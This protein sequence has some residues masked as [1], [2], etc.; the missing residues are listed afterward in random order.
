MPHLYLDYSANLAGFDAGAA[1][2]ACHQALLAS[3]QFEAADIK[4][5]ACRQDDFLIGDGLPGGFVHL[6]LRLLSGRSSGVRRKLADAL[7][8]ALQSHLPDNPAIQ[9][10]VETVEMERALYAKAVING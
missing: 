1:L 5:R 8:A 6:Q 9:L 3:A 10:S 4:G 7:L 2:Q